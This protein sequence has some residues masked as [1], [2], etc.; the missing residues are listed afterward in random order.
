LKIVI[1]IVEITVYVLRYLNLFLLFSKAMKISRSILHIVGCFKYFR[2][3][4]DILKK[5]DIPMSFQISS[6]IGEG[7][8]SSCSCR[9]FMEIG[10][11]LCLVSGPTTANNE[12]MLG[13][14]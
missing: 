14:G 5:I 8:I 12:A 11:L 3:L 6:T 9:A 1:Y 10:S 7:F 4:L 13:P 2:G